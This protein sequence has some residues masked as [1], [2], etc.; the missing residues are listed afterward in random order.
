MELRPLS[1]LQKTVKILSNI[2]K[3]ILKDK[4]L[5]RSLTASHLAAFNSEKQIFLLVIV[6]ASSQHQ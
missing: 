6:W 1:P 4:T 3:N 2:S 5:G